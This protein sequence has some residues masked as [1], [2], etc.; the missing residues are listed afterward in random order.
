MKTASS[1]YLVK[2]GL[3]QRVLD[4][5]PYQLRRITQR[6]RN[7][8]HNSSYSSYAESLF[9]LVDTKLR[10]SGMP[11][12]SVMKSWRYMVQRFTGVY[13]RNPANRLIK[14]ESSLLAKS[15]GAERCRYLSQLAKTNDHLRRLNNG[16]L[17]S[18]LYNNSRE[19]IG[20]TLQYL[21]EILYSEIGVAAC[22]ARQPWFLRWVPTR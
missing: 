8:L 21:S 22:E 15:V 5:T 17:S 7:K 19:A 10:S 1:V 3:F 16:F 13:D 20:W 2:N 6:V 9:T 18:R 4:T 14:Y 11:I 12:Q